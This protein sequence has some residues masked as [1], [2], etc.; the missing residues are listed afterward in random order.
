MAAT[1]PDW[2]RSLTVLNLVSHPVGEAFITMKNLFL[3]LVFAI[4]I[5]ACVAPAPETVEEAAVGGA[6]QACSDAG[7][8]Y[9]AAFDECEDISEASCTEMGG[10]F[11]ACGS[12]CR[13]LPEALMCTSQC[14]PVCS[15]GDAEVSRQPKSVIVQLNNPLE[16][17]LLDEPR[18][19]GEAIAT[20]I[21]RA[22]GAYLTFVDTRSNPW[23]AG[24]FTTDSQ[25]TEVTYGPERVTVEPN[26]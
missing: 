1:M 15:F 21:C 20:Y 14:V 13:H 5:T 2:I 8:T 6:G 4:L 17:N 19:I 11:E 3:V 16:C 23:T 7:G 24:Y 12:A 25:S 10:L 22:P 26:D 9:L 18:K